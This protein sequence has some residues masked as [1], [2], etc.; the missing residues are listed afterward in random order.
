MP[1]VCHPASTVFPAPQDRA[2]PAPPMGQAQT[3]PAPLS[4]NKSMPMMIHIQIAPEK[5]GLFCSNRNRRANYF[6]LAKIK[7]I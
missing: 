7:D 6:L 5:P 1:V 2:A 4:S 3:D